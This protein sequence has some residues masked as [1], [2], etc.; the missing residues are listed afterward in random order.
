MD[1]QGPGLTARLF[2]AEGQ[3]ERIGLDR[4]ARQ[5]EGTPEERAGLEKAA[6]EFEAVFLNTLMKAMRKTVPENEIFNGGGSTKFYQQMHD[7]EMAKA[8]ATANGGLG[9]ADMIVR[10]LDRTEGQ[11]EPTMGPPASLPGSRRV[12]ETEPSRMITLRRLAEI[13]GTAV[14]DTLRRHEPEIHRSARDS[15][16]D[17]SLVLA[18]VLE[19]SGGNAE[20]VSPRGAVGLM[21]LMPATAREVDVND[22]FDPGQNLRGGSRY[23]AQMIEKH[24]GDLSLAL[25][26]YNAGPGAVARAGNRIPDFP[27]TRQYVQR[28]LDRYQRLGGGTQLAKETR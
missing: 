5:T 17:P 13:Q 22:S 2:A 20:A 28:V 3:A 11:G 21:Q 25:A 18:V 12:M 4:K 23:L 24:D 8:L 27:E 1:F 10:Q 16:L 19:E 6:K 14:S 15:G 7:A 9:I 26:A